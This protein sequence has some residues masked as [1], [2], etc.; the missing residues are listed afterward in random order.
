[1]PSA[2]RC[3]VRIKERVQT[4]DNS[5]RPQGSTLAARLQHPTTAFAAAD[6][7][8]IQVPSPKTSS[9]LCAGVPTGPPG[10]ADLELMRVL[11][12]RMW[13]ACSETRSS[14]PFTWS[15]RRPAFWQVGFRLHCL[16]ALW[17]D[18]VLPISH[19]CPLG[20][21]WS[22]GWQSA[23]HQHL[24]LAAACDSA[25]PGCAC[26]RRTPENM[27][28]AAGIV[29]VGLKS[30]VE[31]IR[32]QTLGRQGLQQLQLDAQYLRHLLKR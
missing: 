27:S 3:H 7:G 4:C 24:K 9:C 10:A 23:C 13:P 11:W 12:N 15:L 28:S 20:S 26:R 32:L 6:S 19:L 8:L 22:L 16:C 29:K 21:C 18:L 17:Q 30:L 1:M 14:S 25:S 31:C 2:G 5:L